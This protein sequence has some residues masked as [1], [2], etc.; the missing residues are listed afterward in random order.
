MIR[1]STR[2]Y[3]PRPWSFLFS[4]LGHGLVLFLVAAGPHPAPVVR[5][6]IYD[7]LIRPNE[8]KIIWYGKLPRIT[9]RNRISDAPKPRGKVK[10][11]SVTIA[12]S[13]K[14]VS[15]RQIILQAAPQI[16]L[17]QDL[18][19][20][21]LLALST[22][23][24]LPPAPRRPKAFVPPPARS[25][26][27]RTE[28]ALIQPEQIATSIVPNLTDSLS[29]LRQKKAFVA[30]PRQPKLP[31]PQSVILEGPPDLA[32]GTSSV[33]SGAAGLTPRMKAPVR[34][35]TPP[36]RGGRSLAQGPGGGGYSLE[37][38]PELPAGANLNTAIVGLNPADQL[39]GLLPEGA[40][41]AQ[42][43]AAPTVGE[44]ATGDLSGSGGISAP[45]VFV[46]QGKKPNGSPANPAN[47]GSGALEARLVLYEDTI[48]DAIR[49]TLS[50]PLRPASRTIPRSV[51][52]RFNGRVVYTLVIPAP[53]LPAYSGDWIM[54]F[55]ERSPKS[56]EPAV[57]RAPIPY[58]KLE[59]TVKKPV[60][61]GSEARIQLAGIL[62]PDG[63][64]DLIYLV[65]SLGAMISQ[66]AIEDL[67]R[68]EFRPAMRNGLP[69]EVDVVIEIP[70]SS[71]SLLAS[72]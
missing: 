10:S 49:P 59:P 42:F 71:A 62:K 21:N 65:K 4:A 36:S 63:R 16:K 51:E 26:P 13:P 27:K 14:P 37:S 67:K 46:R 69:I 7:S 28:D 39:K 9:P 54:W 61:D 68:W 70:F 53:N 1:S 56:A 2:G 38:P 11:D 19:A 45:D 48:P 58:R 8:K 3:Q 32:A 47:P 30:P 5:R 20:P 72:Q 22:Q 33:P 43:S 44:A 50:A 29:P 25:R 35:F 31:I 55:A 57:I 17:E 64:F 40:R 52:Y 66:G 60:G 23:P 12:M 24:H 15:S 6:P 34:T 41:P 18:R